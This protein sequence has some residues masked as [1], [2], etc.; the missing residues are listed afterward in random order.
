MA[1]LTIIGK[2]TIQSIN[3][4]FDEMSSKA[5]NILK[6]LDEPHDTLYY[7][8]SLNLLSRPI[9]LFNKEIN[10][11]NP[12]EQ[13]KISK[14]KFH[15]LKKMKYFK[16]E[17]DKEDAEGKKI[18]GLQFI[19]GELDLLKHTKIVELLRYSQPLKIQ[20][21]KPIEQPT[22]TLLTK[23]EREPSK[24]QKAI[25]DYIIM[26]V[27]NDPRTASQKHVVVEAVAG[28]GKTWTIEQATK[29]IPP[30]KSACF[31]A[32][33]VHIVDEFR[34][35]APENIKNNVMTLNSA[36]FASVRQ[37]LELHHK[38]VR[39][40]NK[41]NVSNILDLLFK[42][43][44]RNFSLEE[45]DALKPAV[46]RTVSL[47]KATGLEINSTNLDY[48]TDRYNID[49]TNTESS[50]LIMLTKDVMDIN[51]NIITNTWHGKEE[52]FIDFDDQ[53]WLP[54]VR[55]LP[56]RKY[57]FV[58]VDETQDLNASQ[59]ELTIKLCKS[60]GSII[61]VGDRNQSI[62][63]FRG[64]DTEA[65]PRI[66]SRLDA[67]TFPLSITY[68]CPKS[69]VRL[70][71]ELVPE[72]EYA[73]TENAGYEA[74]EGEIIKDK[75]SHD[76]IDLTNPGDKIICRNNAPLV[77]PCF[78]L[79][80]AGKKASILGRDIGEG[81]INLMKKIKGNDIKDFLFRLE[82]W[83]DKEIE[84]LENKSQSIDRIMDQYETL[85]VLA[86]DCESIECIIV[87]INKIFSSTE[88]DIVFSTIHRAKGLETK[89]KE[90]SIFIICSHNGKQL[91]PSPYA[92]KDWELIQ[93]KN[94][95]YVA[96]TRAK[97][98]MYFID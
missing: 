45:I 69:H 24:Y 63:G 11:G 68:R 87:K 20:V 71:Q 66:I 10:P 98:K 36:G 27:N 12:S 56:I 40:I 83:K 4:P 67:K 96:Y 5:D 59:L 7:V 75:T 50:D 30:T 34:P 86:E 88:E 26:L 32:F 74:I 41:N 37:A 38:R 62:Y 72:I 85:Q 29:L 65:I 70:A 73:T 48:L 3:K 94:L 35:R 60:G 23:K 22:I 6:S 97:N 8:A 57:D 54:I 95:M 78:E 39:K 80:R 21:E 58:F 14:E 18:V 2:S 1:K 47:F 9:T 43:K 15:E 76:L 61:A 64:A 16:K 25:F 49:T 28:S 42:D 51:F 90:N 82:R 53:I 31:L 84:K 19:E 13:I 92:S 46:S 77:H 89:T 44:H 81:L 52:D 17:F 91:M 79:I 93:E 33:N 55:N